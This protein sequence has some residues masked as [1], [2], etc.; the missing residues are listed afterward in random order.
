MEEPQSLVPNLNE[1][2]EEYT[3]CEEAVHLE[4]QT[5]TTPVVEPEVQKE[6]QNPAQKE[7]KQK[8]AK[9]SRA[10]QTKDA[11]DNEAFISDEAYSF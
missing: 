2:M 1:T 5:K 7:K 6:T 10:E 9:K 11:E 8:R 4:P 3:A